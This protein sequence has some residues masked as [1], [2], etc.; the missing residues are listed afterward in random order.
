M[1]A[2]KTEDGVDYPAAAYAYVPDA[3]KPSEWKLRLWENLE[4]KV[5]RAQLGRAA[6]ALSPGG[7]RGQRVQIPREDLAK[8]KAKI[9]AAYRA[10]G[11]TE[12]EI[13]RWVKEGAGKVEAERMRATGVVAL[14][15]DALDIEK[16][17]V[18]VTIVQPGFN[19]SKET[20]YPAEVLSRDF[21]IF[22]GARMY[23]DHMTDQEDADRPV[24]SVW[25]WVGQIKRVWAEADGRVRATAAIIDDAFRAKL[26]RLQE[27]GLLNEMG[28]SMWVYG[29]G[30]HSEVDGVKT[31]LIESLTK[32]RSVDF[33]T[34]AGA[35]GMVEVF[36]S[37]AAVDVDVNLIGLESLREIRPD[38]VEAIETE[39]RVKS[40]ASQKGDKTMEEIEGV[41]TELAEAN[42]GLAEA[43][44]AREAAEGQAKELKEQAANAKREGARAVAKEAVAKADL[45]EPAKARVLQQCEDMQEGFDVDAALKAEREYLNALVEA[46]KVKGMGAGDKAEG[47]AEKD[48]ATLVESYRKMYESRGMNK[49]DA[50]RRAAL[51]AGV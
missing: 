28:V 7:F 38:L 6:A 20:Y 34:L 27:H 9:R 42:K 10:L 39:A 18:T 49:V 15:S 3:N 12:K 8:V 32:A 24:D 40:G 45:P 1:P 14:E 31:M 37:M 26:K 30:I 25:R 41:K 23:G 4:K 13:P 50:E 44:A 51:A 47:D 33:V 17:E 11:V 43:V 19:T 29:N 46:A 22:E 5:T 16:G 35:G 36:E 2:K 48:Q 21:A